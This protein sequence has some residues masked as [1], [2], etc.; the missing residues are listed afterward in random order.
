VLRPLL[1]YRISSLDLTDIG[2]GCARSD[3][4]AIGSPRDTCML[5]DY[6]ELTRIWKLVYLNPRFQHS[7]PI[8]KI[9]ECQ[10]R[11]GP[12]ITI[13]QT[14]PPFIVIGSAFA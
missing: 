4:V 6:S 14:S 11:T 1:L 8:P 10:E 7:K 9:L 5:S 12:A 13:R 3:N 2:S